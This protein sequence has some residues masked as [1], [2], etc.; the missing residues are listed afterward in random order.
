MIIKRLQCRIV[1]R[2]NDLA[3]MNGGCCMGRATGL[4]DLFQ[5]S[6]SS[7]LAMEMPMEVGASVSVY[8]QSC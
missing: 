5:G 2:E 7:H 4:Y 1:P 3:L 6:S 8:I